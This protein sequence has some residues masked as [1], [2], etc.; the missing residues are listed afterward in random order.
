[1]RYFEKQSNVA[2]R[3]IFRPKSLGSLTNLGFKIPKAPKAVSPKI[4]LNTGMT[5]DFL[6]TAD[7]TKGTG[8]VKI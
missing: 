7:L 2:M 3:S 8:N 5:G 6:N 4:G 1:M